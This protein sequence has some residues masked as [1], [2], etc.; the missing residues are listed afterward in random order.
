MRDRIRQL[1]SPS[2]LGQ[3][4]LA[5]R[6]MRG[7]CSQEGEDMLLERFHLLP[8]IGTYID[9]GAGHPFRWSNT[10]RLYRKGWSGTLVEPDPT[11]A[12]LLKRFRRRDRVVQ[13][14]VGVPTATAAM[15]I[16]DDAN[17]NTVD[18]GLIAERAEHGLRPVSEITASSTTLSLIQSETAA[19]FASPISLICVDTEG[20][21]LAVLKSGCWDDA[22]LRPLIV[23]AE[24]LDVADIRDLVDHPLIGFMES[25]DF[26]LTSRMKESVVLV[27]RVACK[28]DHR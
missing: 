2:Y 28:C 18:R 9:I 26:V 23:V 5:L 6:Y 10:A 7:S 4:S 24:I 17:Y 15:A 20:T 3:L 27:D 8:R 22:L 1:T 13:A 21:D 19:R 12:A 11:R 14:L 16:Y 25:H